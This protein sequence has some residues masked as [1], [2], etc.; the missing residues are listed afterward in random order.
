M[1]FTSSWDDGYV[2]DLRIAD[3]LD[4]YGLQGTFYICPH[5][6]HEAEMLSE[7]QIKDL[8]TRHKIGAHT[9]T[10]PRLTAIPPDA[11]REEIRAS[12]EWVEKLTGKTCVMFCYPYGSVNEAVRGMVENAGFTNARTTQDLQFSSSDPLLQP[13]SLQIVP[14]PIRVSTRP[15]WK[16]LDPLG[17]LRSRY[18]RLRTIGVPHGAMT[19]WLTLATYLYDYALTKQQPFF[20]LYGHSREVEKYQMWRDLE[21]FLEYVAKTVIRAA[22]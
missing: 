14:F 19:S 20:H 1:M 11:A 8:S 13:V 17:P 7:A 6:Q 10:H 21:L 4:R 22:A 12:K 5:V 2:L 9:M 15:L 18:K 3:L 16:A